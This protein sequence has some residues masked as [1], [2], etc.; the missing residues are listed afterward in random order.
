MLKRSFARSKRFLASAALCVA[1]AASLLLPN[2]A[3]AWWG[4]G[5]GWRGGWGWHGG[6]VVGVPSVA[7]GIPA[8]APAY[9]YPYY[10]PGYRWVPAHYTRFGA[11]APAHWGYR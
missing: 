4:P 2:N 7:V 3:E 8:Y 10:G 5:W 9:P 11:F 6:F 1:F